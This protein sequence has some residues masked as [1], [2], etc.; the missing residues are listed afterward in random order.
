MVFLQNVGQSRVCSLPAR[1]VKP[2]VK[3]KSQII[4]CHLTVPSA[5]LTVCF[6][7]PRTQLNEGAH[8]RAKYGRRWSFNSHQGCPL[9]VVCSPHLKRPNR[10]VAMRVLAPQATRTVPRDFYLYIVQIGNWRRIGT[11]LGITSTAWLYLCVPKYT[12]P[13]ASR[14]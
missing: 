9:N 6:E 11:S 10:D 12:E 7:F 4:M 2:R 1:S 13:A 8:Q 14:P 3:P 5:Q